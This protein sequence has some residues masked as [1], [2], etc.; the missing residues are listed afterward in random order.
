MD[1]DGALGTEFREVRDVEHDGRPA[2]AV[3]G[4]R[5]YSTDPDDLW[6]ALTC[7]ERLPRWFL[8]VSGELRLGGRYR[9][10]GNAEGTI[11][12]CDPPEALEITWE[13]SGNV[14]W[15]SVRLQAEE[16]G[17][18]LTLVHTMTKDEESEAHWATYGAGATG[19]GWELSFFGLGLHL[20]SGGEAIDREATDAWLASDPGKAFVRS[21]AESWGRAHA[22]AGED[23]QT[24]RAMAERTAAFYTGE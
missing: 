21:A 16:G 22:E 2:R 15:V 3:V 13:Y 19:V 9:L 7:A 14:S 8:P 17:S 10:E 1:F 12:R 23:P 6:D 11:T 18:R 20:G 4:S 24:A 5:F